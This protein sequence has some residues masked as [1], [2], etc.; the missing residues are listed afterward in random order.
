[1]AMGRGNDI[2]RAMFKVCSVI[3]ILFIVAVIVIAYYVE[4]C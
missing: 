4:P 1:M 2:D 3:G